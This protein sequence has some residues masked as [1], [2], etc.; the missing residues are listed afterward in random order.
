MKRSVDCYQ[1]AAKN[2]NL[3]AKLQLANAIDQEMEL[4][5]MKL[6]SF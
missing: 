2:R 1:K 3:M 4:K 6:K 5:K